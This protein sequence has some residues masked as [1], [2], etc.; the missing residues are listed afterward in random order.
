VLRGTWGWTLLGLVF[1]LAGTA[2]HF[3]AVLRYAA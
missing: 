3:I 2:C 1:V